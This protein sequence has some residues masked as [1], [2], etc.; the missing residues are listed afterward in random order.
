MRKIIVGVLEHVFVRIVSIFKS[1][2]D[3]SV[4]VCDEIVIV[5]NSLSTK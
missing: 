4:T 1:Y 3:T 5:M 2:A